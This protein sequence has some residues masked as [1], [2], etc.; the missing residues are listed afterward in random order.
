L[1]ASVDVLAERSDPRP[2]WSKRRGLSPVEALP[3]SPQER[4]QRFQMDWTLLVADL[5]ARGYLD[6]V[7]P[8][9]CVDAPAPSPVEEVLDAETEQRLGVGGL[10]P[11]RP[12]DWEPD[13]FYSLIEVVHDLV[14][15]PRHREWHRWDECGWHYSNF[16]QTP[17]RA[18]YR[19]RVDQLLARYGAGLSFAVAGEDTGRLVHAAGD[20]RDRLVR[21]T[22]ATPSPADRGAVE[23]AVAL[24]RARAAG[25]EDKRSAVIALA[26]ILEDRRSLLKA[27]LLNR[28]EGALFYIANGFDVRHRKADQRADYDEAYLDWIFWW[29]LATLELTDR[30]Q[31]RQDQP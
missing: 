18:L 8:R 27:E 15:R 20:D 31:N 10:W 1:V 19:W 9:G 3:V 7:A 13:T 16:A 29:Y 6:R 2:Y 28:D 23:H 21:R 14:A 25:R 22:L 5:L 12:G 30:L 17:A 11:L 4:I 26:R 24:F